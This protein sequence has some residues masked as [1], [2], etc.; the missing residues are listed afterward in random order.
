MIGVPFL[1][2]PSVAPMQI[3]VS[4][5]ELVVAALDCDSEA[6]LFETARYVVQPAVQ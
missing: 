6:K 2:R 1:E 5:G 3:L 4:L